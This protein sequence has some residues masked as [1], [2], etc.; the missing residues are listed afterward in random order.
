[1]LH[2]LLPPPP[3]LYQCGVCFQLPH[4]LLPHPRHLL[5]MLIGLQDLHCTAL[6]LL[7]LRRRLL[8][9]QQSVRGQVPRQHQSGLREREVVLQELLGS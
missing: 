5:R 2:L 3:L 9:V 1:M 7:D 4:R 8:P 6:K